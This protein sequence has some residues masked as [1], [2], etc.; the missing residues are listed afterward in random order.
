MELCEA[1]FILK[2]TQILSVHL[3]LFSCLINFI[4]MLNFVEAL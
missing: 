4:I 2:K 3:Y 1:G